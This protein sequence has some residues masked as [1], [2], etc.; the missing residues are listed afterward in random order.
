M[1]T[2]RRLFFHRSSLALAIALPMAL[3]IVGNVKADSPTPTPGAASPNLD[4]IHQ[5][6]IDAWKS[7]S[8]TRRISESDGNSPLILAIT[9][10]PD[11]FDA[12]LWAVEQMPGT[13]GQAFGRACSA[14]KRGV[15]RSR[16]IPLSDDH[17]FDISVLVLAAREDRMDWVNRMININAIGTNDIVRLAYEDLTNAAVAVIGSGVKVNDEPFRDS[18]PIDFSALQWAAY[19]GNRK[20][21]E[22]L[23]AHGANPKARSGGLRWEN[24]DTKKYK[25]YD[26][27]TAAQIAKKRKFND[28]ADWLDKQAAASTMPEVTID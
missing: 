7:D 10:D 20:L 27:L 6:A 2:N 19:H 12:L 26:K 9:Q 22:E 28:L 4:G 25:H 1:L 15:M 17:D 8:L 21:C 13:D 18:V 3:A 14:L 24:D 16:D 5:R 23:V 11:W